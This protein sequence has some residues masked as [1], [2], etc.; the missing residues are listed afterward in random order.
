MYMGISDIK[1]C[2]QP[3]SNTVKDEKGGLV[4][5]SHSILPV[6]RNHCSQLL[7]VHVVSDVRQ[8]EIHTA[9]LLVP[10]PSVFE[11]VLDIEKL[12]RHKLPG[13]DQIPAESIKA[14][15]RKICSE[16]HI[17]IYSIW[18]KE[19]LPEEWKKS[20]IALCYKKGDK[21]DCSNYR[22]ISLLPTT[23]KIVSNNPASRLTPYAEE[24]I[25]DYQCGFRHSRSSSDRIFCICQ[26]L[27]ENGNTM[28]QCIIY[29]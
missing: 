28:K 2:Y 25:V 18:N 29:L 27:E 13:I 20:I 6:W 3:R 14:E 19:E 5:D 26:I 11:V 4:T 24:V 1:K 8:T 17:L 9:E 7:N 12:K 22:G 21:T 16:I 15:G 23:N 10:E